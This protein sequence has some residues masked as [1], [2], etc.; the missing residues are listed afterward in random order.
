ML[1]RSLGAVG[2]AA[3]LARPALGHAPAT[4]RRTGERVLRVV[5]PF[6]FAGADPARSGHVFARMGVGEML[7]GADPD[8]R[9]VPMLAE[10]WS[11]SPDGLLHR[12]V[13]R[14][15]V[16]FH[17][18]SPLTADAAAASLRHAH[19]AASP[20]SRV[21]VVAIEAA[22][23][24]VL[25][26]LSRPFAPLPAVLANYASMILAPAAYDG[27]GRVRA[28]IGTGPFR[29]EHF[30][31]PLQLD[32]ER[33]E[34]W[35]GSRPAV[36]RASYLVVSQGEA[37]ATMAE[38]GHADLTMG[39]QPVTMARLR[40]SSRLEILTVPVP[41]TRILKLNAASPLFADRR[42]RHALS[43]AVDRQG[44]ATA[45][46]RNPAMAAD[47]LF[48]PTLPGWHLPG[49]P[50][51]RDLERARALLA[52]AG[53]RPSRDGILVDAGSRRFVCRCITY[54]NWPELPSIA[55][56]L[57][58]Q[59]REIGID[60]AVTIGNSSD[61]PRGHRDGTLEMAL[62]ARNYALV[63]D[64]LGTLLQDFPSSGGD[65]GAMGWSDPALDA[66]LDALCALEGDPIALREQ[67]AR[68]L[69]EALPVIPIAWSE[70]GVAVG[71]D[72]DG[73]TVDPFETSFRLHQIAWTR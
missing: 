17:D 60:M 43:L 33:F 54:I 44:I 55:T 64:P 2:A 35:W 42:V 5:A 37:R 59:F 66:T 57:Q 40:R 71:R 10:R 34:G 20:L 9:P 31:P 58:A 47:Q 50:P 18:N 70:L 41:R 69:R 11:I 28:V 22:G 62:M 68:I 63:P 56:A 12:F 67:A 73:V 39:L 14:P 65:W 16:L 7:L 46:L 25:V 1:R 15:R 26:R 53:W 48:P 32:V 19:A 4:G 8:G 72:L 61:I 30:S 29:I 13:L 21:P 23:D 52:E 6:E 45:V 27:A 36:G 49:P 51:R 24:A 38:S 3:L